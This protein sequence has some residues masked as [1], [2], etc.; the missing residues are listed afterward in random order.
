MALIEPPD[1]DATMQAIFNQMTQD[2]DINPEL[3][4]TVVVSS[5]SDLELLEKWSAVKRELH[6]LPEGQML[7]PT[8]DTAKDV[9][10][11]YHGV[12]LEMKKR[13][14]L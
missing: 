12:M 7:N 14:L 6:A 11:V 2:L 13:K 4:S 9:G 8:T 5:L 3:L 10:A 1:D